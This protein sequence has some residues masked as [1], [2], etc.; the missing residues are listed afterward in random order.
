MKE[1]ND[2][3]ALLNNI[4]PQPI[5]VSFYEQKDATLFYEIYGAGLTWSVRH[6]ST[7][8]SPCAAFA[9]GRIAQLVY[10]VTF[11][12]PDEKGLMIGDYK[13]VSHSERWE[14]NL[15]R[16]VMNATAPEKLWF[17][18]HHISLIEPEF[19]KINFTGLALKYPHL[20]VSLRTGEITETTKLDLTKGDEIA[21]VLF[22]DYKAQGEPAIYNLCDFD[23]QGHSYTYFK[24]PPGLNEADKYY[25]ELSIQQ[26]QPMGLNTNKTTANYKANIRKWLTF[27][28]TDRLILT[29]LYLQFWTKIDQYFRAQ[30]AKCRFRIFAYASYYYYPAG[31]KYDLSN[32]DL[33]YATKG[34]H[35][36]T[37]ASIHRDDA[38]WDAWAA[39]GARMVWRPNLWFSY[40]LMPYTQANNHARL[41]KKYRANEFLIDGYSFRTWFSQGFN[42]YTLA[43][44]KRG[45]T[46]TAAAEEWFEGIGLQTRLK[47]FYTLVKAISARPVELPKNTK[48]SDL[49]AIPFKYDE[50]GLFAMDVALGGPSSRETDLYKWFRVAFELSQQAHKVAT[51]KITKEQFYQICEKANESKP[52]LFI[53]INQIKVLVEGAVLSE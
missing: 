21:P 45:L 44:M 6:N 8:Q 16:W 12:L 11:L 10:G 35:E 13:N 50:F 19:H 39:T 29:D 52:P 32:F 33:Y 17:W 7:K 36:L 27:D 18:F 51:G 14:L 23:G 4:L 30:G 15:H 20:A 37:T 9:V 3:I 38:N 22:A 48:P 1:A 49:S 43:R 25:F 42:Y 24:P 53:S 41:V 5:V 46:F 34:L 31:K 26:A 47:A 28:D 40:P 2:L